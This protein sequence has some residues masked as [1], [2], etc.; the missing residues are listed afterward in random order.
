MILQNIMVIL[1]LEL[2][3][4]LGLVRTINFLMYY[5]IK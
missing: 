1:M 3:D 4:I 5:K 2:M